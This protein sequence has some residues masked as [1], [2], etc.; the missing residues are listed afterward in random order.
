MAV[1]GP[2]ADDKSVLLGNYNGTPS[3]YTTLLRGIQ[4][5]AQGKVRYARG[6]HIHRA[7]VGQWE[8]HPCGRPSWRP[9]R[10]TWSFC[11]WA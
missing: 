3:Q 1:I 6:C 2:N 4:E 8:E 9:R 10:A 7:T 11:A 5:A